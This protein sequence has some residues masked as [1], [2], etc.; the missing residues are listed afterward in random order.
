VTVAVLDSVRTDPKYDMREEHHFYKEWFSGTGNGG[1]NRNKHQNCLRLYHLPTGIVQTI[2]GKSRTS[3]ET[4]AM[5]ELLKTLEN[6]KT[7]QVQTDLN[8][9]RQE[10]VGSGMR[11]D[12]MRTYRFQDNQVNDHVS[13]KSTTCKKVM[14]GHFDDL[15]T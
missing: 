7:N 4:Q 2:Q 15:W 1:Q 3:N 8:D 11:A 12:K 5:K 6:M 9:D 14:R 13:N 10:K